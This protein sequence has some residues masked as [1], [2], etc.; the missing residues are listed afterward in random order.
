MGWP[1]FRPSSGPMR[2][3]GPISGY[4][5]AFLEFSRILQCFDVEYGYA[6]PGNSK[7]LQNEPF[8]YV[9]ASVGVCHGPMKSNS[10]YVMQTSSYC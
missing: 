5:G 3:Q 6:L 4:Q 9:F 8:W 7:M 1:G 10:Q 2:A